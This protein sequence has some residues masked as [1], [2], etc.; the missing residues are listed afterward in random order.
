VPRCV[1][2]ALI[3]ALTGC[4]PTIIIEDPEPR[5]RPSDPADD[6]LV[7]HEAVREAVRGYTAAL[8]RRD[9]EVAATHVVS[10]TF[11]FH[12]DLRIAALRAPRAQLEMLDLMSVFS[13]LQV[14]AELS[15]S[16]LEA[17]DGR[18]LFGWTVAEGLVGEGLDTVSL[19]EV[20]IDETGTTAQIR[21]DGDP[22]VFLRKTA[23]GQAEP[24]WRIDFPEM[25]RRHGPAIEAMLREQ[26]NA[27]GKVRTAY[28]LL[29]VN[30]DEFVDIAILDGPLEG[31]GSNAP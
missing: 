16:E 21:I 25:F 3:L 20:W 23:E 11:A 19:D 10:E 24:R 29:E 31:E 28:T 8:T 13:V 26:V 30:T 6:P 22:V 5:A 17:L 27:D 2:L 9:V 12:D 15:R 14:R 7:E 18:G 1:C 4:K